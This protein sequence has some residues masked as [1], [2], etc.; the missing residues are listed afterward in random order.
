MRALTKFKKYIVLRDLRLNFISSIYSI[1]A[2]LFLVLTGPVYCGDVEA[3]LPY[4]SESPA[5]TACIGKLQTFYNI[6][7]NI[8]LNIP[9]SSGMLRN[10]VIV[11]FIQT[12]SVFTPLSAGTKTV[13]YR[14]T[15]SYIENSA[16][17]FRSFVENNSGNVAID[18]RWQPDQIEVLIYGRFNSDCS[19]DADASLSA[20]MYFYREG[21]NSY[22]SINLFLE[23]TITT[24]CSDKTQT[25]TT[26]INAVPVNSI[27]RPANGTDADKEAFRTDVLALINPSTTIADLCAFW[28]L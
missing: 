27:G 20:G 8:F 15:G 6:V 10:D 28:G 5:S 17:T 1:T 24:F 18:T 9:S 16:R 12:S 22:G 3:P 13:K 25:F 26:K 23:N 14:V 2:F 11:P 19:G 21:I 4:D 7:S